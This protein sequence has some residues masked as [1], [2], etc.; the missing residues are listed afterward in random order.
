MRWSFPIGR[1]LGSELRVHGT[2]L[3]LLAYVAGSA[4]MAAGP[5]AALVNTVYVLALFACVIAHEYGHALTA[6]LFGIPTPD[7]TLLP[8]GGVARLLRIPEKPGQEVLVALAGPAVNVVIFV[9]LWFGAGLSFEAAPLTGGMTFADLPRELATLNLILA[10]FNMVPAFPMDGGRVLRA[11]LAMVTTRL[12]AT[13]IASLIGQT[14]AVAFGLY[15]LYIGSLFYPLIAVFIFMAA[16]AEMQQVRLTSLARTSTAG[17]VMTTGF[18]AL[19]STVTLD[20]ARDAFSREGVPE[21]PVVDSASRRITGFLSSEDLEARFDELGGHAPITRAMVSNVPVVQT[22]TPLSQ[23]LRLLNSAYGV[24]V[25]D[26]AGET[27]G[28]ISR[29]TVMGRLNRR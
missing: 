20:A 7:I 13:R 21:F 5:Q 14:L 29:R 12:T 4:W 26:S 18:K 8:I 22:E 15:G 3:I 10:A 11:L 2:F 23:V 27:T 24:A 17:E 6:R 1:L 16:R 25:V 9:I 28:F 19:G